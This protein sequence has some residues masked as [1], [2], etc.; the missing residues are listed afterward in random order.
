MPPALLALSVEVQ[1]IVA[2]PSTEHENKMCEKNELRRNEQELSPRLEHQITVTSLAHLPTLLS[3][4]CASFQ[5]LNISAFRST[6]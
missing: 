1:Q 4:H 3:L 5:P 2:L 6:F